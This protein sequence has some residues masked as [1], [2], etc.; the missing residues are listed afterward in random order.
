MEPNIKLVP[1]IKLR[2]KFTVSSTNKLTFSLFELFCIPT[3][4]SINKDEL[5]IM[6]KRIF[7]KSRNIAIY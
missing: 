3:I 6:V 7:F 2:G 4:R 1:T 5:N